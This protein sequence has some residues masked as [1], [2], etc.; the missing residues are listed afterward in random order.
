MHDTS[1]FTARARMRTAGIRARAFTKAL[2][3]SAVVLVACAASVAAATYYVDGTNAGATDVGPGT[4]STPYRTLQA[5][6]SARASAGNTI[7]VRP[8]IYRE[9]VTISASG[10]AS[11]RIVLQASGPGAVISGADDFGS[12]SRWSAIASD[13]YLASSVTWAPLQV[14]ADGAR[15]TPST[16]S[17][18]SLPARSYRYV[19]GVGLYVNAGGGNPGLRGCEVGRRTTGIFV[20]GA[21]VTLDGL[22]FTRTEDRAV[23]I[24]AG[25][26]RA[27]IVNNTVTFAYKAGIDVGGAAD[28]LIA[29]NRVSDNGD[30]G[31][32]VHTAAGTVIRDNESFRNARPT[33]RA[34][35]GI[36]LDGATGCTVELNQC[37]DNQDS[38]IQ[39]YNGSHDGLS[40]NNLS[41]NNGDHGFDHVRSMRTRHF[42]DVAWDNYKDGFSF[43]GNSGGGAM[44]NCIAVDNGLATAEF[45]L[46][47][48]RDSDAGFVSDHNLFWNS[49]S[50]NPVKFID[51]QYALISA[52]ASATGRDRRSVQLDPRFVDAPQGDFRLRA[53]SPAIDA[54]VG[55]AA[56]W[57]PND[58]EGDARIDD[59]STADTG[60]GTPAFAD[61]GAHEFRAIVLPPPV[62]NL[63]GNP[64]FESSASGWDAYG[65]ATLER[66]AGGRSGSYCLEA[67]A[68][69]S[70]T[71]GTRDE[72]DWV[73]NALAAGTTYRFTAWVRSAS[74]RG[75][76]RIKLREFNAS[77]Q[78]G[79][80]K[81]SPDVTLSSSWQLLAVDITTEGN[82]STLDMEIRD[83]P[84]TSGERFQID[85][86]SIMLVTPVA[87]DTPPVVSAPATVSITE[88]QPLTVNVSASD[89]D[90]DPILSFTADLSAL[91]AGHGAVFTRNGSNTAGTLT[92]TPSASDGRAAPYTVT[93]T[94][95]N[96]RSGVASTLITVG[97][98][99]GGGGPNLCGNPG[100]ESGISGWEPYGNATLQRVAGGR[101]GSYCMEVRASGSAT[102]GM[103]DQP[104]WV[105][106]VPGPGTRYRY[107]AWVRS[108]THRGTAKLQVREYLNGVLQGVAV[109]TPG[110]TL[111]PTWQQITADFI[112]LRTG[113]VIETEVK[114]FP[115]NSSEVFQIDDFSITR[116]GVEPVLAARAGAVAMPGSREFTASV[117][118]NPSRGPATLEFALT[119][120]G[121]VNV[122]VFDVRGRQ[123]SAP[124]ET[125]LGAGHH[126]V[127]LGGGEERWPRGAYFY[128]LSAP[129]GVRV[130][131]FVILE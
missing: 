13:V 110:V 97:D 30:H 66:V 2:V 50:R 44:Y 124:I 28:V 121:V 26:N 58:R 70:S 87:S 92:W 52:Y 10:S 67:R 63:C 126:R 51:T 113:S 90:G 94:A 35:A 106:G 5:A 25:A 61:L 77:S 119:R 107:S 82:G 20:S 112:T 6:V 42:H 1:T 80:S 85:D 53:G 101:S 84:V 48:E 75:I 96:D 21:Y 69:G 111:S 93:F 29:G 17:P 102:I 83:Y 32:F 57:P 16:A 34:A 18:P 40:R 45:D 130:G 39:F 115:A 36:A 7:I 73:A 49:T 95:T 78:L 125:S 12:T 3:A 100:F 131:K 99:G 62:G 64:G 65:G 109:L 15:L 43:E 123:M 89:A 19:S 4:S 56:G 59:P 88:G 60:D 27:E 38:G 120:P 104:N 116:I 127:T 108:A 114:D 23:G 33:T 11:S 8:A 117:A 14:F 129:E 71:F 74:S 86:V 41:W 46:W 22:A 54:A 103:G 9:S 31:I 72:P 47:V 55:G 37:Y 81:Y 128:R 105:E 91:P 118:R 79:S 68:S 76:A 24:V 98:A 122:L